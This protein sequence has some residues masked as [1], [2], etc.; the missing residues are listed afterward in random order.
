LSFFAF[1]EAN[2]EI[3][4]S[5]ILALAH[6]GLSAEYIRDLPVYT[7]LM[8]IRIFNKEKIAEE[9]VIAE[10]EAANSGGKNKEAV[11]LQQTKTD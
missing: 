3:I 6:Q 9:R 1:R 4:H 11:L 2:I 10:K 5:N 7:Y 8:Y